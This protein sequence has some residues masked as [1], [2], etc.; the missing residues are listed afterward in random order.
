MATVELTV[1]KFE[2]LVSSNDVLL[3]D[4]RASW[5]HTKKSPSMSWTMGEVLRRFATP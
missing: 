4:L 2:A 3:V 5:W 1:K